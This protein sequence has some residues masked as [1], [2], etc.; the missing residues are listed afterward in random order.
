MR[1]DITAR[2]RTVLERLHQGLRFLLRSWLA[3][4]MIGDGI[5]KAIPVQMPVPGPD[6]LLLPLGDLTPEK[7]LWTFLGASPVF[8]SFAGLA[9]LAG[10]LLLL[11]PRTTLLGALICAAN[12]SMAV[13]VGVCYG[14][15]A[16]PYLFVLFLM[17][18]LLAAPDLRRLGNLFLF[19]RAV[20]RAEEPSP[21]FGRTWLG[22]AP[23]VL[24]ILAA[25]VVL[26]ANLASAAGRYRRDRPPRPP[27][28]GIW[29][30]E[31]IVVEGRDA[32]AWSWLVF[33][34]L[35]MLEVELADGARRRY[36]LDLDLAGRTMRLAG[37]GELRFS[38]PEPDVL[39]LEGR[40]GG[41]PARATLRRMALIGDRFHWLLE[42]E[43]EE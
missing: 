16:T 19:N 4:V 20:D 29:G 1:R 7:L 34:R 6:L 11:V 15:P 26:G 12:L 36:G 43:E 40:L 3:L 33:E 18:L 21:L 10:G 35:G 31:E 28:H 24:L 25:V 37:G 8:Q 2:E 38:E 22:R 17:S 41:S 14:L 23:Q 9:E 30:V 13:V 42:P 32:P 39:L 27:L 5:V